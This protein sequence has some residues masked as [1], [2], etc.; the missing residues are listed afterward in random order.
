M[1]NLNSFKV[2]RVQKLNE[3]PIK[4]SFI[5]YPATGKTTLLKLLTENTITQHYFPTQGFDFKTV[6][7][8][9]NIISLWDFGGQKSYLKMNLKSFIFGSDLIFVVT[10]STPRNVLNSK[11][12]IKIANKN[13]DSESHI[14]ALANKQ[15]LPGHME[16]NRVENVLQV[17]TY[18][19]TAIDSNE[20]EKIFN[21]IKNELDK[22]S[23]RKRMR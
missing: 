22:A 16:T 19:C 7:F 1:I 21:V 18:G 23:I 6:R 8:G 2:Q 11:K 5:G 10:D 20:R 14:I 4:I 13:I 12:L 3:M 15:D 17:K 9:N